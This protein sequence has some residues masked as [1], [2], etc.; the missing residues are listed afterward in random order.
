MKYF[1]IL[2][3]VKTISKRCL[4]KNQ[5]LL[6]YLYKCFTK[7]Q[8]ETGTPIIDQTVILCDSDEIALVAA[9]CGFKN[10]W[11][12]PQSTKYVKVG[13][14]VKLIKSSICHTEYES[15][16]QWKLFYDS[17]TQEKRNTIYSAE[18]DTSWMFLAPVTQPIKHFV[19]FE[20]IYKT[21]AYYRDNKD[22]IEFNVIASAQDRTNRKLFDIN[23]D[24]DDEQNDFNNWVKNMYFLTD[25]SG[26]IKTRR[27]VDCTTDVNI[28]GTWYF[29][30]A[31]L[32]ETLQDKNDKE[33]NMLFWS[34]GMK[35]IVDNAQP[36]I[37]IDTEDD[38]NKLK[39]LKE[40][41]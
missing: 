20:E 37:D 1:P 33:Q 25:S 4:N 18:F 12:E 26:N 27:G 22:D 5:Q 6:P 10:V 34:S 29:F 32:L 28:D 19:F 23:I 17:M 24:V 40:M 39:Y 3:P 35:C 38:L 8:N 9:D 2:V 13:N 11:V 31:D 36:F 16:W 7:Y 41:L 30:N 14:E 21:S 15:M